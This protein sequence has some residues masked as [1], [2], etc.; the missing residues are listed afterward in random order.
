MLVKRFQRHGY[1]IPEI[2]YSDSC[3]TDRNFIEKIYC[4]L[5]LTLDGKPQAH[6]PPQSDAPM[7]GID[8]SLAVSEKGSAT[9]KALELP[10]DRQ[11]KFCPYRN[12]A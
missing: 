10:H 3:C 8:L 11:L 1:P 12:D 5:D 4:D 2:I 7:V 6:N 9:L